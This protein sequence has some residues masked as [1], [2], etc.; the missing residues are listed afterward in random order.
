MS[1]MHPLPT[2]TLRFVRAIF[3]RELIL[4]FRNPSVWLH[5]IVFFIMVLVLFPLAAGAG[6]KLLHQIGA[7]AIWIA[8]LLSVL[9]GV[10]SLF[11]NDV[12]D[13]TLEQI[14]IA[15]HSLTLW[16]LFKV[17]VHWLTGGFLLV[18]LSVLSI[19]LFDFSGAE[20][21]VLAITL[22]LGTPVLTLLAGVAAALTVLLRTNSI[23]VPLISL[24]LQL[25]ILIFATGAVDVLRAGG[26]VLPIL[27]LLAAGLI[28]AVLFLPFAIASALRLSV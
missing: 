28:L 5:A 27:A 15:R 11:R 4:R 6:L 10:D 26:D 17:I 2:L 21:S 9:L 1:S 19:P 13:G 12:E 16:V 22:F 7:A 18:I 25:P 8:A 14:V 20:A 24:P 23:L 3:Y